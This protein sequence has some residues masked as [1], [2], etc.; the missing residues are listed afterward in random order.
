M[1]FRIRFFLLVLVTDAK[2]TKINTSFLNF[3]F[4]VKD[5]LRYNSFSIHSSGI[6]S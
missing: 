5:T 3:F 2:I 1:K 6:R 4:L